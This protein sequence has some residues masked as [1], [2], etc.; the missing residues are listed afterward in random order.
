MTKNS[1]AEIWWMAARPRTLGAALA[2]IWIGT[3]L[4]IS[5]GKWDPLSFVAAL[6]GALLIQIGTNFANDYFDFIKGA[7]TAE[8]IGPTRATQAGLIKPERMRLAFLLTFALVGLPGLY[9]VYR[10]GWPILVLGLLSVL[11]GIFY[12]GGPFPLGYLGLGDLFVLLFFGLVATGGTFWV[13][14]HAITSVVLL[15][16]LSPGFLATAILVV[17]NLRD[18]KTDT[19]AGKKTLAVRWGAGFARAEYLFCM[20][21]GILMPLGLYLWTPEKHPASLLACLSILPAIPAIK[22]VLS[23]DADPRLNPILGKTNQVLILHSLLFSLGWIF[24]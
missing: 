21:L 10:G 4:A 12:T 19:Q 17:N 5:S 16:A 2:P 1:Q 23:L 24:S 18:R 8:R 7:D 11:S 20:G 14:T 13:H 9:L 22:A 3:A 15:A 6:L